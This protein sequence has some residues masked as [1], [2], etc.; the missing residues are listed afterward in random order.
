MGYLLKLSL[1]ASYRAHKDRIDKCLDSNNRIWREQRKE[2]PQNM[3]RRDSYV[4]VKRQKH[5]KGRRSS[6]PNKKLH[7]LHPSLANISASGFA[8]E[9]NEKT[10]KEMHG[11]VKRRSSVPNIVSAVVN[12]D[13][14][15]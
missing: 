13:E 3:I 5:T 10:K 4:K 14:S 8:L 6:V 15:S 12:E 7:E 1:D 2:D 9:K 11:H